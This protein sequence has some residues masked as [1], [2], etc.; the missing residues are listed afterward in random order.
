[1]HV[2][3]CLAGQ[4]KVDV[5]VGE[6]C[7]T[8][9]ALRES[10]VKELPQLCVEGFDV[11]VGGRALDDDEGVV[12]LTESACLDVVPN[13]RGLSILALREAGRTVSGVGLLRAAQGDVS[14]CTLYL[15]AGVPIDCEDRY[16]R[17]PLHFA[18]A[19]GRLEVATLLLDRGSKALDEMNHSGAT[20][21]HV[22][23]AAASLEVATLL[24]DRGSKALDEEND[25][26]ETPL[27]LSCRTGCVE[28]ATLLLD[29]GAAIDAKN[30][31]GE[32]P[33]H[34]SCR[35]GRVE[36]ARLLLDRGAAIDEKDDYGA[37]T[38]HLSCRTGCV[39]I[40]TLLLDR[41]AVIDEKDGAGWTPLHLS[42]REERVEIARLLLDRGCDFDV[43]SYQRGRSYTQPVLELL[44][45][46]GHD[47]LPRTD[48]WLE[49]AK[50]RRTWCC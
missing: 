20:P 17:T 19:K 7:R 27:H 10:I 38:L 34:V 29:R 25:S 41:G 50:R 11:S 12:S 28:I 40:A 33:L 14:R 1:M 32:T 24:L 45:Q 15:D 6:G 8:L 42:C 36:I 4:E 47:V 43:A 2:T 39:E 9:Q 35:R 13:T 31:S 21:L 48:A 3:A 5:E 16:G 22:S 49:S 30:Y 26:G 44:S 46:R 37:T 18:C 23:C